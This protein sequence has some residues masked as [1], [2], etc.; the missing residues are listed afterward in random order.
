M[1]IE[2]W[3]CTRFEDSKLSILLHFHEFWLS[4]LIHHFCSNITNFFPSPITH[5]PSPKEISL[6]IILGLSQSFFVIQQVYSWVNQILDSGINPIRFMSS[7]FIC[8]IPI[9]EGSQHNPTKIQDDEDANTRM[10]CKGFEDSELFI[11][12]HFHGF[13][14]SSL[15]HHFRYNITI[16]FPL[17]IT[18]KA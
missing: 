7:L 3:R 11:F 12:L 9:F 4:S 8:T 15:I 6:N 2:G 16:F 18:R 17:P 10:K 14:S 5:H 13:R 1:Q